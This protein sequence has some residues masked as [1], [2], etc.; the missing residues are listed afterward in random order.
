MLADQRPVGEVALVGAIR[1]WR[2]PR[3]AALIPDRFPSGASIGVE[4]I[5]MGEIESLYIDDSDQNT[6][7]VFVKFAAGADSS[8]VDIRFPGCGL[9]DRVRC[10][11]TQA[12]LDIRD[13]GF[14]RQL[15]EVRGPAFDGRGVALPTNPVQLVDLVD[16]GL[17]ALGVEV[18]VDMDERADERLVAL[19]D[20]GNR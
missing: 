7:T 4:E 16:N 17:A 10:A 5:R 1:L 15:D 6:F 9:A 2:R 3:R 8:Q 12:V 11:Q 19:V 13:A 20:D 18:T 14:L